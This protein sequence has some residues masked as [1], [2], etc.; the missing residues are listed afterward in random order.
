MMA[1][2]LENAIISDGIWVKRL[3]ARFTLTEMW[4]M[5]T[6]TRIRKSKPK[7][8]AYQLTDGRGLFLWVTPTGGKLWRWKYRFDGTQK[9]MS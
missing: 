7:G 2:F 3:S 6:D 1:F 9:Q 4:H 8:A 5:L